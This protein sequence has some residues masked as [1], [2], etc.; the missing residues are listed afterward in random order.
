MSTY[1]EFVSKPCYDR[2]CCLP[3]QTMEWETELHSSNDGCHDHSKPRRC[4]AENPN[5]GWTCDRKSG[6]SGV[7]SALGQGIV[8]GWGDPD[9]LDGRTFAIQ[10]VCR[11]FGEAHGTESWDTWDET[12]RAAEM[13]WME[14]AL[15]AAGLL[16]AA[17]PTPGG[18]Q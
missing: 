1:V 12:T 3:G 16:P 11:E 7:H 8:V 9:A 6:H 5:I 13:H 15:V 10:T 4:S 2:D 14:S 17:E 18:E